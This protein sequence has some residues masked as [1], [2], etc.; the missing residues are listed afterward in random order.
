MINP[1]LLSTETLIAW[2]RQYEEEIDNS[3][4][5]SRAEYTRLVGLIVDLKKEVRIRGVHIS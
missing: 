1:K 5:L 4:N 3:T 2:I